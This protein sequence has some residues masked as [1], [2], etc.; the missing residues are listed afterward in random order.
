[1][2]TDLSMNLLAARSAATHNSVQ[3]AVFKKAHEMQSELINTLMQQALSPPP[4]GQGIKVDKQ[5]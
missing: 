5:A 1:M 2:D 4:P 3:I